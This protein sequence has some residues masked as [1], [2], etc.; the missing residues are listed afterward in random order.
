MMMQ[1]P[2]I[3]FRAAFIHVVQPIRDTYGLPKDLSRFC[4]FTNYVQAGLY[5]YEQKLVSAASLARIA[6]DTVEKF[7]T[8]KHIHADVL[9]EREASPGE[10]V[11]SGSTDVTLG[12]SKVERDKTET[13][14]LEINAFVQKSIDVLRADLAAADHLGWSSEMI[15]TVHDLLLQIRPIDAPRYVGQH[16][17]V[18]T[19]YGAGEVEGFSPD[20]GTYAIRLAGSKSGGPLR[21]NAKMFAYYTHVKEEEGPRWPRLGGLTG[22]FGR[23]MSTSEFGSPRA[24]GRDSPRSVG[25]S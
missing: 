1:L 14:R 17:R 19:R 11:V 25:T 6:F 15:T 20:I 24:G 10:S 2:Y 3:R 18:V 8:V 12:V 21:S 22:I 23:R 13:L 7:E 9:V 4:F 5:A 16:A